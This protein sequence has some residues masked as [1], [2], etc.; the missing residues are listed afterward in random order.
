MG[1]WCLLTWAVFA[2][3]VQAHAAILCSG[4]NGLLR[5]R[6]V[7]K[8]RETR[9][10]PVGLGLQGPPGPPGPTG[11]QGDK[12]VPGPPGPGAVVRDANGAFVGTVDDIYP[13]FV[14]GNIYFRGAPWIRVVREIGGRTLAF[15]VGVDPTL[16]PAGFVDT[17][18]AL[19]YGTSDC[20]G[21]ASI[22]TGASEFAP[23][24]QA[25]PA[26]VPFLF[27]QG[28]HGVYQVGPTPGPGPRSTKVFYYDQASCEHVGGAF[29]PPDE[30]CQPCGPCG[31]SSD[32]LAEAAIKIGRAH[33]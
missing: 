1:K 26:P 28:P 18:N 3:A 31:Y 23:S 16:F 2:V 32:T 27:V 7:C 33:V 25:T 11:A 29:T 5:V 15:L 19:L 8:P 24:F 17:F 13:V 10:D 30:C 22:P 4:Q 14:P 6:D 20:S 9:V 21:P 12:G